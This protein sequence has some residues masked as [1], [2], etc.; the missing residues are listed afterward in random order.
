MSYAERHFDD[1]TEPDVVK[2]F[3][4]DNLCGQGRHCPALHPAEAA[5]EVGQDDD[6]PRLFRASDLLAGIA[7]VAVIAFLTGWL[8]K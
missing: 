3:C 6:T 4:C 1:G 8:I 5:T 7:I 2:R